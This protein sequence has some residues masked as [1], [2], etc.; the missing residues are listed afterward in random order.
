MNVSL[1]LGVFLG[2]FA[3]LGMQAKEK[4]SPPF[5]IDL[6]V[7]LIFPQPNETYRPVYPFPIVFALTGATKAWPY[8]FKLQWRLE[9]NW[10]TPI[11]KE[12]VPIVYGSAPDWLYSSGSLDPATEP[13]FVINATGI[14][15]NTSYTEWELGWSLSVLQECSPGPERY[16]KYGSINFSTSSSGLLPNYKPKGPCPLEIQHTRFLDNRTTPK[17]VTGDRRSE[18]CVVVTDQEGEGDPCSI[19]TGHELATMVRAEM[20]RY[21]ECPDNQSWP[22]E[23]NLLGPDSCRRLYPSSKDAE[24]MANLMLPAALTAVVMGTVVVAFFAM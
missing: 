4:P 10:T 14:M 22:D 15:G 5:P 12:D 16:W 6:G 23:K 24:D 19:D 1:L 17:G 18:S 9:G 11:K 21:A 13:Y 8:G 20:L 7:S 3:V 2:T